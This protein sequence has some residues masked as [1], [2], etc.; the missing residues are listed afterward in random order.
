MALKATIYKADLNVADMDRDYYAD[1]SLTL[2]CHPSENAERL[3]VRLLAFALNAD[4]RLEFTRGLS[5]DDEPDL[6]RR[7]LSGDV[8]QWIEVGL[9]SEERLKK[10][11]GR[12]AEVCVIAYG[13]RTAPVWWE[14]NRDLLARNRRL[15]VLY[16]PP[17]QSEALQGLLGRTMQLQCTIQDGEAWFS[18]D[19]GN[20]EVRLERWQTRAE[21]P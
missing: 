9:P 18:S 10:A 7:S 6:W 20:A 1:H 4:E 12:A 14:K 19:N 11:A 13:P 3:M 8:E 16:L 2:A 21:Q 15:E 17:E 5:T